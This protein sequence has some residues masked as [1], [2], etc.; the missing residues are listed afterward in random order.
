MYRIIGAD[1]REYGPVSVEQMRLW[2]AEGRV[3]A[4]MLVLTSGGGDWRPLGSLPEF[5]MPPGPQPIP[6]PRWHPPQPTLRTSPL[7]MAGM[8]LGLISV[9]C[10]LCC[11][12]G[13]PFNVLGLIFSLVGLSQINGSPSVYTG[14]GLATTGLIT[15]LLSL[16]LAGLAMLTGLAVGWA[17]LMRNLR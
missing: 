16:A 1:Q 3:N 2:L 5:A 4:Q 10:G 6:A 13:A 8:I 15:S 17:D 12:Y 9:T 7:A 11:C 14:K